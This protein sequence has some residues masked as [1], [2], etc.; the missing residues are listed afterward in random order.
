MRSL[1]TSAA[2][3]ARS[4]EVVVVRSPAC[5]LCED[6]LESLAELAKAYP[7]DVRVLEIDS[8][9]GRAIV[10]RYRP[11][12]SPAVVIDGRLFS[13]GRLPSKKLRRVL[14]RVT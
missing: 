13:S 8:D 2:D 9:E 1:S 12:L 3:T 14:E 5:H 4:L 6:A 10:T 7:F 11:A